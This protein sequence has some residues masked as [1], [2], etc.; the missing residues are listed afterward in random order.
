MLCTR[1]GRAEGDGSGACRGAAR[2]S[3]HSWNRDSDPPAKS[4]STC[5]RRRPAHDAQHAARQTKNWSMHSVPRLRDAEAAG[6]ATAATKEDLGEVLS[7]RHRNLDHAEVVQ[8][9]ARPGT[10]LCSGNL[11]CNVSRGL[12]QRGLQ[13]GGPGADTAA[14][15][16][17]ALSMHAWCSKGARIQPRKRA[18]RTR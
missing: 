13:A 7:Q 11:E 5:A 2:T 6:A 9:P 18:G 16:A 17:A 10:G 4:H 12:C 1:P 15:A 14:R 8:E 3:R